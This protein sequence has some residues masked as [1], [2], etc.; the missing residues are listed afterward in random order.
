MMQSPEDTCKTGDNKA[1]K[2]A[3]QKEKQGTPDKRAKEL[4]PRFQMI[5]QGIP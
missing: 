1:K 4:S 2:E 5:H 3:W